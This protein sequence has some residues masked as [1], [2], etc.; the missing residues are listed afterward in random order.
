M[1]DGTLRPC[2][3]RSDEVNLLPSIEIGYQILKETIREAIY[4]KPCGH[5]FGKMRLERGMSH[6][7]G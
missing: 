6:I 2:L 1:S 3:G 5:E 7:G 4:N